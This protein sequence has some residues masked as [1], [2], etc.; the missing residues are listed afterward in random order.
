LAGIGTSGNRLD[1]SG[2]AF[3]GSGVEAGGTHGD[4]LDGS[5]GL[6][7]GDGVTGIDRT[8]EG[9]GA[10][11]GDDLGDLVYV[12]QGGDARQVVLAVGGGGGQHVAVALA[13]LGDQGRDVFRQLVSEGGVVGHQDLGHAGDLGGSFGS[14][15][16]TGTGDQHVDIAT[17]L[18]RG[19]HNVQSG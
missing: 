16:A 17:D 19:G 6:H 11:D 4:H 5:G 9:V 10:L 3:G 15:G 7:G 1:G 13:Q 14:G 2:T 18:L 8:L 12:Q